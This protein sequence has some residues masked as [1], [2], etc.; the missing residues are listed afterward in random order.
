MTHLRLSN[1]H[2]PHHSRH[3]GRPPWRSLLPAVVVSL[4]VHAVLLLVLH[5]PDVPRASRTALVV[6]LR[7]AAAERAVAPA[8]PPVASPA[9]LPPQVS[10]PAPLPPPVA[11][12]PPDPVP[13]PARAPA[14]AREPDAAIP[15][16]SSRAEREVA[17]GPVPTGDPEMGELAP[18]LRGRRLRASVWVDASGTVTKAVVVPNELTPEQVELL[19]RAIRQVRFTP[20]RDQDNAAVEAVLRTLLCIDGAGQLD[21]SSDECW[22]PQPAQAR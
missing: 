5:L 17:Q 22:K 20:A 11:A 2:V 6:T 12:A 19:E 1:K 3:V 13:A 14:A 10:A 21:A 8:A 7:T 18:Q 4:L 15:D 16:T 9:P